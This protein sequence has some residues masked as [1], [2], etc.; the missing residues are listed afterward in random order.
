MI[1]HNIKWKWYM[2]TVNPWDIF[3][4]KI[5]V[6]KV[7][8]KPIKTEIT[9]IKPY[10]HWVITWPTIL[11]E[12]LIDIEWIIYADSEQTRYQLIQQLDNLFLPP[13]NF[14][15]Y[16]WVE[17][18]EF[19]DPNWWNWYINCKVL[20][21]PEYIEEP[22]DR[23]IIH[24]K[25]QLIADDPYIYWDIITVND[26]NRWW[27]LTLPTTLPTSFMWSSY[28][29]INYNWAIATPLNAII[30]PIVN[31]ATSWQIKIHN[32]T[33][34]KIFIVNVNLDLWDILEIDTQNTIVRKNWVDITASVDLSSDWTY[35]QLWQNNII[36]DTW[37]NYH[38]AN[39][40]YRFQNYWI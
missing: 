40:E 36:F 1:V 24:W 5:L 25:V 6:Q 33:T 12:R 10:K 30:T 20:K 8:F 14:N 27:W 7:D 23:N 21:M 38:T 32:L 31:N 37:K 11:R 17:K 16:W 35:L 2:F 3:I 19:S 4:N 9:K 15:I 28:L 18:L 22:W 34:N 29:T 13:L 26:I 39:I